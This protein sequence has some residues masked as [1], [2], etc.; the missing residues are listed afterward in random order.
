MNWR[1]TR[2]VSAPCHASEALRGSSSGWPRGIRPA[3]LTLQTGIAPRSRATR[4][5]RKCDAWVRHG[6]AGRFATLRRPRPTP[7]P[8]AID[9][10]VVHTQVHTQAVQD[11]HCRRVRVHVS[12]D[13]GAP[14]SRARRLRRK[15]KVGGTV[16]SGGFRERLTGSSTLPLLSREVPLTPTGQR[17]DLRAEPPV[18]F[19]DGDD[20]DANPD[21][22]SN[23]SN[24]SRC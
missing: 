20:T 22:E 3:G 24:S 4:D 7:C 8:V 15:R 16:I 11:A 17:C 2:I 21:A 23:A 12:Y 9:F 1:S 14:A 5:A 19:S 6:G 10:V 13:D 18:E